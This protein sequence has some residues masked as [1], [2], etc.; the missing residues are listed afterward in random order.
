[1]PPIPPCLSRTMLVRVCAFTHLLR[2][3]CPLGGGAAVSDELLLVVE[4]HAT[5]SLLEFAYG[6]K[7]AFLVVAF[8]RTPQ[9]CAAVTL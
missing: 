5:Q 8:G 1:M 7:V 6:L 9:M 2:G 3:R 4:G